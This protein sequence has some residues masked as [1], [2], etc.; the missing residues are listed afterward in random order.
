LRG[1]CCSYLAPYVTKPARWSPVFTSVCVHLKELPPRV[2]CT[3][4]I[5]RQNGM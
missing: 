3:L 5:H 4:T 2:N 1:E